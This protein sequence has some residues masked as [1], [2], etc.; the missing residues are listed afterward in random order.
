MAQDSEF[1]FDVSLSRWVDRNKWGLT[2]FS[3]G[4]PITWW[5]TRYPTGSF[6][7]HFQEQQFGMTLAYGLYGAI[8]GGFGV[9]AL[10]L[11]RRKPD[12]GVA[13][14]GL[15]GLALAR[16]PGFGEIAAPM[17]A[18]GGLIAGTA[19]VSGWLYRKIT[20]KSVT[21]GSAE[22]A[23]LPH[24]ADAGLLNPGGL[25]LGRHPSGSGGYLHYHGDKPLLTIGPPRS[26][27]GVGTIVPNL[28]AYPGSV[29]VIDPKGENCLMTVIARSRMGQACYIVDPWGLVSRRFDVPAARINPLDWVLADPVD[30]IE[31]AMI[32]A[33]AIV[34]PS[35]G[36]AKFWD[37]EAKGLLTGLILYV[38]TEPG[39]GRARNLARVRDLMAQDADALAELFGR[40]MEN[41]NP[42]V[43]AAGARCAQKDEKLLASVLASAQS[44]TNFLD[45]PCVRECLSASDFA[46][47]DLKRAPTTIYLVV[48]SDRLS[49]FNRFLRLLIQQA[50]TANARDILEQPERPV[51]FLLDEMAAL[52]HL[53]AI[54]QAF[55]LMPGY[56]LVCWGFVQTLSQLD[57]IYGK[58]AEGIIGA[59]G[60]LQYLGSRDERTAEYF[61]KLCGVTTIETWTQ[62]LSRSLSS[63]SSASGG[64]K[65]STSSSG[66][67]QGEAPRRLVLADELMTMHKAYQLLLVENL[68][69]ITAAKIVWHTD[70]VFK[71]RGINL[72]RDPR[73]PAP[74]ASPDGEGPVS[75]APGTTNGPTMIGH[76]KEGYPSA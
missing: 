71:D 68:N 5:L 22:W 41:P 15:A 75:P 61:S 30:M 47:E 10:W 56:G 25:V 76:R 29:L 42:V 39:E 63:S 65:S 21:F 16:T 34:V 48:P 8:A 31:R 49:A 52:G 51:L 26:G 62:S 18:I 36:E 20:A 40:M 2:I 55:T 60:V 58:G 28:L 6:A 24:L 57:K 50:I 27:K 54:E 12:I 19:I 66:T 37:E 70:P 43:R 1:S 45:S 33:D 53:S 69:P 38:A 11:L 35:S 46:F 74:E 14:L 23:D 13:L 7:A 72:H 4:A 9:F 67:T 44:H 59:C 73:P 32:I 3:V 64:S 17:A